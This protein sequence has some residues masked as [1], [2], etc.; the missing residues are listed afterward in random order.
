MNVQL[1]MLVERR[2][3]HK[4]NKRISHLF[5][6]LCTLVSCLFVCLLRL[7]F[8]MKKFTTRDYFLTRSELQLF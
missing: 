6:L 7:G 4:L 5:Q 2:V 1:N 8:I 3:E